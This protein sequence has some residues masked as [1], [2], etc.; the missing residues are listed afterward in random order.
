[1]PVEIVHSENNI[2]QVEE[3]LSSL[4]LLSNT[5]LR[6]THYEPFVH[7]EHCSPSQRIKEC[8]H[9]DYTA[10]VSCSVMRRGEL[11]VTWM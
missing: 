7:G 1:M 5:H 11:K 10:A 8:K 3:R 2:K 4:L 9:S 6:H